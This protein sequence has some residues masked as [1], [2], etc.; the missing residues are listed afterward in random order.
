MLLTLRVWA[1]WR[2]PWVLTITL[3][4]LFT[5]LSVSCFVLNYI[6]DQGLESISFSSFDFD[7]HLS[8]SLPRISRL[9]CHGGAGEQ[10]CI[11]QLYACHCLGPVC[12]NSTWERLTFSLTQLCSHLDSDRHSWFPRLFF[13][14]HT[15]LH[16]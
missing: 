12:S 16:G 5:T 15:L 2:R 11:D 13:T 14:S 1:V 7:H 3:P 10:V 9:F 8:K 4:I 6:F